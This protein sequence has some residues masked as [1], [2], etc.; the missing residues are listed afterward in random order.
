MMQQ[1]R[2][3]HGLRLWALAARSLGIGLA[4]LL[5]GQQL[6]GQPVMHLDLT[7][8]CPVPPLCTNSPA[9]PARPRPAPNQQAPAPHRQT[10]PQSST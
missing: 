5:L 2:P 8:G 9:A 6:Q 7:A 3:R 10:S 4:W 1:P